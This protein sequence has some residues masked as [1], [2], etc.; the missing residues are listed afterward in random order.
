MSILEHPF[1]LLEDPRGGPD[2]GCRSCLTSRGI[3]ER[4][5]KIKIVLLSG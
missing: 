3:E 1:D 5:G 2:G 4:D